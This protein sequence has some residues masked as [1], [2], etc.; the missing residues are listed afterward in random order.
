MFKFK[1]NFLVII[2]IILG[3][4]NY[5]LLLRVFGVSTQSDA[6]LLATSSLF[7]LF[8]LVTFPISQFIPYYNEL[9]AKSIKE[10]HHFYNSSIFFALSLG[11]IFALLINLFLPIIIKL[12]AFNID[13]E[14]YN[15]FKI[16]LQILS[17]GLVFYPINQINEQLFNAEMKF[18]V[19][20]ILSCIPLGLVTLLQIGMI[21]FHKTNI[22]HLAT[23]QSIG[24]F[25]IALFGTIYIH[26]TLIHFKFV[27]WHK[28]LIE[29]IKNSITLKLGEFGWG[30]AIPMLFNNFL[31]S[32][33]KGYISYFYYAKKILDIANNFT[34]GPSARILRS[35]ISKL[36]VQKDYSEIKIITK[37]FL[38]IGGI[39]FI[40]VLF[41]AYTLQTPIL[42]LVTANKLNVEDFK[43]ITLIFLT[44]CPWYFVI[45][46][47]TPFASITQMGKKAN[48]ILVINIIFLIIFAPILF[49]LKP[50]FGIYALGISTSIA[51]V[52]NLIC[53][54]YI[55]KQVTKTIYKYK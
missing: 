38:L 39:A 46:L 19:P 50:I 13:L 40:I 45:F 7:V 27:K 35:K 8:T 1:Y 41:S 15:L 47:E 48:E 18:S 17:F 28:L 20:Y 34:I 43:I 3:I 32:F 24:L 29:E 36:L 23:A 11:I 53:Y 52:S 55:S 33:P 6:Y 10:S 9:K 30:I 26:K 14:R 44:L 21:C 12:F 42:K 31:V 37:N 49:I 16:M 22:I 25:V 2:Q 51:Q 54:I 4:V 5:V